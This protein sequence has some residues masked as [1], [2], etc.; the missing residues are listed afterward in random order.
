[1][2]AVTA[3]T[4]WPVSSGKAKKLQTRTTSSGIARM[5]ST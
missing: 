2:P 1:M 4:E 3:L 5:E